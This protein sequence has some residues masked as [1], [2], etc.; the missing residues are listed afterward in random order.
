MQMNG[1]KQML[2]KSR[3]DVG[4]KLDDCQTKVEWNLDGIRTDV[5]R[6]SDGNRT[7]ITQ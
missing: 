1:D 6:E 7:D 4:R 5:E 3:M 2:V